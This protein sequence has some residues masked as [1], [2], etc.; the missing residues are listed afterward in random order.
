[1]DKNRLEAFSDGVIA[2][3]ITIMVLELKVPHGSEL[4]DLRP[5]I[6][7]FLSYV[8]S[9]VYVGIYWNNHHHLLHTISHVTGGVLWANLHLLFWLSLVPFTTGWMG[10]NHFSA[11]PLAL[12]GFVLLMC[13]FAWWVL[14]TRMVAMQGRQSPLAL[15]VG[16][17]LK[18][19]ISSV[20]YLVGIV[21]AFFNGHFSE[22]VYVLAAVLW[23]VPDRRFEKA[24]H[25]G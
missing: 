10:E 14:Q 16:R 20:L 19:K 8:L 21:S 5:L 24:T 6:P 15:A 12:Y 13:A 25:A 11:V 23:L 2:I 3:I 1:M 18:G 17:D 4:A 22:A 7:V 9:F